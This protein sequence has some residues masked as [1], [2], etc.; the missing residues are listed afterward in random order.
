MA[1]HYFLIK[2]LT[3]NQ[4]GN[5]IYLNS[6]QLADLILAI[7]QRIPAIIDIGQASHIDHY[8][9][10]NYANRATLPSI[11]P[12][13]QPISI[14]WG[15]G[16][17]LPK[18]LLK[19]NMFLAQIKSLRQLLP[20]NVLIAIMQFPGLPTQYYG[21]KSLNPLRALCPRPTHKRSVFISC[22]IENHLRR[23]NSPFKLFCTHSESVSFHQC[24]LL[25]C[26]QEC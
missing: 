24:S 19:S 16:N 15:I 9:S 6:P 14:N 1:F 10:A 7:F 20:M 21:N 2:S 25:L 26:G 12:P 3:F 4:I 13:N 17:N 11:N 23:Q 5:S 8:F 22:R 18:D